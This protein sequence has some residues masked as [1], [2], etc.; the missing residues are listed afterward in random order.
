M[1]FYTGCAIKGNK[2]LVR[3]YNNG[4]R[5]TENVPFKPSLF[6]RSEDSSQYKTLTGVNVRRMKFDT[7][8]D[9]RQFG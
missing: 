7:I 4:K 9:C 2:I 8:Y 6:I 1:K 5:F 3:G